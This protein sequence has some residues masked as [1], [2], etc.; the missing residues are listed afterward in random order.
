MPDSFSELLRRVRCG[1]CDAA[2]E[3]WRQYEPLLR[4]EMRLRLRDPNLRQRFDE[5]D[6]C[7]S[8]MASFFVRAAAGQ[9]ELEGPDQLRQL[10]VKMGR[11][12]LASLTRRHTAEIRDCRNGVALPEA[13]IVART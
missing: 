9:F 1:D 8:V 6:I 12:K 10:L 5:D 2:D 7:Q 11:N 13:G 3:L 4:R